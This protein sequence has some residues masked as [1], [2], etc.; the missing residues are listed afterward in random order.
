MVST[1]S[2]RN[3]L[4]NK[5]FADLGSTCTIYSKTDSIDKWGDS[6]IT[7]GSGTT[8]SIV[9]YNQFAGRYNYQP[10]G[11]LKENE[12][13]AVLSYD[14]TIDLGYKINFDSTDYEVIQLEKNMLKNDNL[15]Y[16]IRLTKIL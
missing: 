11:D 1:S 4:A 14:T 10:F 13:D 9:P 12:T 16:V 7:Y 15:I 3:K 6:T 2:I 5:V 8:S